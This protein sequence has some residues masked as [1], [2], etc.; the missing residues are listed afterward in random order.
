M[1]SDEIVASLGL[2]FQGREMVHRTVWRWMVQV[3]WE[4]SCKRRLNGQ[5]H[6]L[7]RHQIY[8]LFVSV[9][10]QRAGLHGADPEGDGLSCHRLNILKT[11][12]A[13][14]RDAQ[15]RWTV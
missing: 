8:R 10:V 13:S 1:K 11:P 15:W 7:T 14:R 2:Y 9:Y 3:Q 12:A 4:G 5:R 6:L